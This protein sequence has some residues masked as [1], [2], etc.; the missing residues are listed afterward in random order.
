MDLYYVNVDAKN[1]E[2]HEVHKLGCDYFPIN[3]IYLGPF[4]DLQEALEKARRYYPEAEGCQNCCAPR[5]SRVF[6]D[7]S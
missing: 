3:P 1:T 4:S 5:H 6:F 7:P 2:G